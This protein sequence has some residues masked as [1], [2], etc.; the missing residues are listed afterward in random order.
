MLRRAALDDIGGFATGSITEDMLTSIRLQAEGWGSVYHNEPLA[1]GIAAETIVPFHIQRRRWGLGGWQVFF[2]ANPFF[3]GGLSLPQRLC[4][5]ASLIYP[6]EGFQKLV[7]YATPPIALFTGILPMH[8]M[9]IYYLLH[10]VPY[11]AISIF[12]FNE[13]GR[14]YGGNLL[15]E[16]FSMGKFVTYMSSML[17]FLLPKRSR[18]FAVTP[19]GGDSLASYRYL[20]PQIAVCAASLAAIAWALAGLLLGRRS[21]EFIIAVN[22]LWAL[23][24]TGL[25]IAIVQYAR[26][27]FV[28]RRAEFRIRDNVPL[29]YRYTNGNGREKRLAVAGDLTPG[30]LSI[31]TVGEAPPART[32]ELELILPRG[33]V[34]TV[35]YLAYSRTVGVNGQAAS[36]LG[37]KLNGMSPA[38][39]DRLS[40]YLTGLAVPKYLDEFSTRYETYLERRLA[41]RR[42]LAERARRTLA[43]LPVVIVKYDNRPVYGAMQDVS[44]TGCLVETQCAV[45]AGTRVTLQTVIG[46][47]IVETGGV[48]ARMSPLESRHFPEALVGIRFDEAG[49]EAARRIVS[50]AENIRG[51]VES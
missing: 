17:A 23:Y 42:P 21:D 46:A 14:G 8:A 19:K 32:I 6:F 10:F 44:E 49:S 5:L 3:L 15:L 33:R 48:V 35:G 22:S 51:L 47:D 50:V 13:M 40:R 18:A 31:V 28:Q 1:F 7:F 41:E 24:N 2:K 25:G 16:Q 4:Y 27:K 9:D 20:A 38:R 43:L 29:F 37:V 11:Y 12:A 30:G 26:R 45:P 36:L 34:E 39:R